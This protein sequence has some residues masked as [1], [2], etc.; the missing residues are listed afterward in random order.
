[1]QAARGHAKG[2]ARLQDRRRRRGGRVFP[3]LNFGGS[4][5]PERLVRVVVALAVLALG[6][7]YTVWVTSASETTSGVDGLAK[8]NSATTPQTVTSRSFTAARHGSCPG[9][10]QP[11]RFALDKLAEQVEGKPLLDLTLASLPEH[12]AIVVVGTARKVARPVIFTSED[13]PGGGPAAALVAGVRRA[14][15]EPSDAI[16]TLPRMR[17]SAAKQQALCSAAWMMSRALR[18]W[19]A[20]MP[21]VGSSRC[22][23]HCDR[24]RLRRW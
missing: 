13:P 19:S 17:R 2:V 15:A 11:Q 1:M 23:L 9:R 5:L 12:V 16:V 24:P 8:G 10:W 3:S 22:S 21:T 18:R 7:D 4:V 20:L 6:D 14:L